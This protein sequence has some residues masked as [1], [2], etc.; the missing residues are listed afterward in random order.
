MPKVADVQ[1]AVIH[2]VGVDLEVRRI[3]LEENLIDWYLLECLSSHSREAANEA[4]DPEVTIRKFTHP[5][6]RSSYI[7]RETVQ[8]EPMIL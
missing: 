2:L 1:W 5:G 3:C 4:G 6:P 8:M 7:F